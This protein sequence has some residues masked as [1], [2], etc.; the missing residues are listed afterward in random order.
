MRFDT[1]ITVPD[2]KKW[3]EAE[4]QLNHLAKE[5][6]KLGL[7]AFALTAEDVMNLLGM[8]KE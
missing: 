4:R 5:L 7:D 1:P 3:D 8:V 2:Q 6:Y